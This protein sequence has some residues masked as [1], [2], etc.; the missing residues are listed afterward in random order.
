MFID[1]PIRRSALIRLFLSCIFGVIVLCIIYFLVGVLNNVDIQDSLHTGIVVDKK[2]VNADKGLFVDT[3]TR[4]QIVVEFE[5]EYH[6]RKYDCKRSVDVDYDVYISYD[7]GDEFD[8]YN[9][10]VKDR[11]EVL[12]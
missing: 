4:Y 9:P 3:D 1:D 12:K 11:K 5:Y 10:V 6:G 8:T 7:I 2:I